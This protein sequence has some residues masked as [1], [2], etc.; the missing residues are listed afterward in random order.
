MASRIH[1]TRFSSSA[2]VHRSRANAAVEQKR[3]EL[4]R[5]VEIA[6]RDGFNKALQTVFRDARYVTDASRAA[7]LDLL[8]LQK[9]SRV[10]EIGASLGQHTRLIAG[11]CATVDALEV[12]PEQALFLKMSCEQENIANVRVSVGGSECNL[13]YPDSYFDVVIMNYVLEWC[14]SRSALAAKDAHKLMISE[15]SRVL[16]AGGVLFVATK[17]RFNL[18]LL[19]G[20]VDEHCGFRFGNALPRP[21]MAWWSRRKPIAHAGYLHSYG[22]LARIIARSGFKQINPVLALPD[23]RFPMVYSSFDQKELVRLRSNVELLAKDRLTR[24]LLT[25]TPTELIKWI[26]PSLVFIAKK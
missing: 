4:L 23:A 24:F 26:A 6:R 21:L 8:P 16:T 20:A 7:Y 18:R 17:N 11:K 13:P 5:L 3:T 14:A 19:R 22:T 15:C 2:T 25:K 9:N 1:S 10:L 12:V